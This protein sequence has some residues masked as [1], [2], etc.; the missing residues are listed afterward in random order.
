MQLGWFYAFNDK[1]ILIAIETIMQYLVYLYL[2]IQYLTIYNNIRIKK[3]NA[4]LVVFVLKNTI[5]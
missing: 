2:K 5:F 1:Y 3:Y 4:I